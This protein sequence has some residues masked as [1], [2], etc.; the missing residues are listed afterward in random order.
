M[1]AKI[2]K[3]KCN[4]C[5]FCI[6]ACGKYA[7]DFDTASNKAYLARS[8]DCI[9]CYFCTYACPRGA[10]TIIVAEVERYL[11]RQKALK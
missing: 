9:D 2:H 4:G 5:G 3:A 1:V 6:F 8:K 11:K 7:L 10:I